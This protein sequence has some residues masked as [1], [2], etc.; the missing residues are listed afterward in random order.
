MDS[1]LSFMV[2]SLRVLQFDNDNR[3]RF[4]MEARVRCG[5][6]EAN[7]FR[8]SIRPVLPVPLDVHLDSDDSERYGQR[9]V[10]SAVR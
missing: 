10:S 6:K 3:I 1:Y 8:Q 5:Q 7:E 9:R 2:R 4:Y